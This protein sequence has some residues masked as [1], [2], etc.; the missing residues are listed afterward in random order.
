MILIV[1]FD[2]SK[3]WSRSFLLEHSFIIEDDAIITVS[4]LRM[5]QSLLGAMIQNIQSNLELVHLPI[6][7]SGA[8]PPRQVSEDTLIHGS[9]KYYL[10]ANKTGSLKDVN[11][12]LKLYNSCG[13]FLLLTAVQ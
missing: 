8:T 7:V 1:S 13:D 12:Y 3:F 6:P 9:S 10:Y 2:W 5:I 11:H 4:Q